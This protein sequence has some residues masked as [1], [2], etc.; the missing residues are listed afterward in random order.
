MVTTAAVVDVSL[1]EEYGGKGEG[2]Y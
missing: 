2:L 1:I